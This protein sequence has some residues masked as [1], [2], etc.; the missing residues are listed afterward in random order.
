MYISTFLK[1]VYII[2]I[3]RNGKLVSR[4]LLHSRCLPHVPRDERFGHLVTAFE[5]QRSSYTIHC[6]TGEYCLNN[7]LI[8]VNVK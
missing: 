7:V 4:D 3:T 1:L 5:L 8:N 6:M 2:E